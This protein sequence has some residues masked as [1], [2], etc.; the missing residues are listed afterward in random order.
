M[1]GEDTKYLVVLADE[2]GKRR[3][4]MCSE[5]WLEE[6][7]LEEGSEWTDGKTENEKTG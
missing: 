3:E 2:A 1:P 4:L 7:H 6:R 5:S